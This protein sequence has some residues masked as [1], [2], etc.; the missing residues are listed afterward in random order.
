MTHR[1]GIR[2]ALVLGGHRAFGEQIVRALEA[3][4]Y[5]VAS[6]YAQ[7]AASLDLLVVNSPVKPRQ[8]RFRA[9]T[10]ADFVEPLEQQLYEFVEAAQFALPRM[11][12]G[13]S[14]VQISSSG[15]LGTWEGVDVAAAGAAAV[16]MVRS[17]ALEF[18]ERGIRVNTLA[19]DYVGGRSD[20]PPMRDDLAATVVW[21]GSAASR[22]ISG[23]AILLNRGGSLQMALSRRL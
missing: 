9:M 11:S 20:D 1:A 10:D 22:L 21:L 17:M 2:T 4:S 13:G 19:A 3:E 6:S 23:E 7:V 14:I 5:C 18:A 12:A 8:I 15:H 16:A